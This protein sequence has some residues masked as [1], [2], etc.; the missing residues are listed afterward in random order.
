MRA[1]PTSTNITVPSIVVNGIAAAYGTF[2]VVPSST[3]DAAVLA[4]AI[5]ASAYGSSVLLLTGSVFLDAEL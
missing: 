1:I 5:T 3:T 4:Q 2:L